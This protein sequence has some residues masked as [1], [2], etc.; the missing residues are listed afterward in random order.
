VTSIVP[1]ADDESAGQIPFTPRAKKTLELSLRE[2]LRTSGGRVL[3]HHLLLGLMREG[4][5]VAA[6]VLGDLEVDLDALRAA[7]LE[8][9]PPAEE[10]EADAPR[11]VARVRRARGP[12]APPITAG[13]IVDPS[14]E[15]RRLLMSAGARALDDGRT[16]IEIADVE[17]ALRRR[18]GS[19]EPPQASTG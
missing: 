18:G 14:P 9:L 13:F 7:V 5:G 8:A 2:S 19:A 12:S 1:S 11:A 4:D 15:V 17:E 6:R 10:V 3:P 16:E